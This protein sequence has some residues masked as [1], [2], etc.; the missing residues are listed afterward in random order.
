MNVVSLFDGISIARL[1]LKNKNIQVD[2]YIAY[3]IDKYALSISENNHD[4]IIHLG[5]VIDFNA[6]DILDIMDVDLLI[7]GSPCQG[8][9]LQGLQKGFE[10]SRS[11]LINYFFKANEELKPKHFLLENVRMN[12]ESRDFISEVLEVEPLEINSSVFVPQSRN[13]LYWTNIPTSKLV[14]QVYNPKDILDTD[15]EPG[16]T[17]KGPPRIVVPTDIFGCLTAT[18]YKGIRADGRPLVAK[19]FGEFDSIRDSLRMLTPEECEKLQGLPVGYTKGV[20]NTQRYKAIGN[21][22]TTQVIEHL[23]TKL[24]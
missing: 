22:F 13:R 4:D 12:K 3:E 24:V 21:G 23:L 17:R 8:F 9:S 16:T 2:N 15:G 14:Q 7:A 20:S 6:R 18:Y 1:A 10:D 19:E 5:D 11:G